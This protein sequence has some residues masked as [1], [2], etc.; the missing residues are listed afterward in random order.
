MAYTIEHIKTNQIE[1]T[2]GNTYGLTVNVL[3]LQDDYTWDNIEENRIIA[4]NNSATFEFDND[5]VYRLDVIENSVTYIH[6]AYIMTDINECLLNKIKGLIN[7]PCQ[8]IDVCKESNLYDFNMSVVLVFTYFCR[9]SEL[10]TQLSSIT[11]PKQ[12]EL[13]TLRDV[14]YRINLYCEN[15]QQITNNQDC[16]CNCNDN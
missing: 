16:N 14:L 13:N 7:V 6:I 1:V 5:G 2:A 3:E 12:L 8:C 15:C 9:P 11:S 10:A 4:I